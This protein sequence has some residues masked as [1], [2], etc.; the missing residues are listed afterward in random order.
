MTRFLFS[1]AIAVTLGCGGSAPHTEIVVA[2]AVAPSPPAPVAHADCELTSEHAR[3]TLLAPDG[4]RAVFVRDVQATARVLPIESNVNVEVEVVEPSFTLRGE[5][6]ADELV[7]TAPTRL[8]PLVWGTHSMW[9]HVMAA[10]PGELKLGLREY[11]HGNVVFEAPSEAWVGC[12]AVQ[13]PNG[14]QNPSRDLDALLAE[15]GASDTSEVW[16]RSEE[17]LE[18][19]ETPEGPTL[20]RWP[21]QSPPARVLEQRG[22]DTRVVAS[23]LPGTAVVGWVPTAA[24]MHEQGEGGGG[25]LGSLAGSSSATQI[26]PVCRLTREQPLVATHGPHQAEMGVLRPGA[27]VVRGVGGERGWVEIGGHPD[28]ALTLPYGP[29]GEP[30]TK[31]WVSG[32]ALRCD[33]PPVYGTSLRTLAT[34]PPLDLSASLDV[35]QASGLADVAPGASCSL[36]LTYRPRWGAFPC[37]AVVT[38][39]ERVLFGA[40]RHNGY[41]A[42]EVSQG[43]P[44]SVHAQDEHTTRED[45]GDAAL[46]LDTTAGSF[47][48]RD[49]ADGSFGVY[50][51]EGALS[52]LHVTS[53]P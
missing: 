50:A 20:A 43:P 19:R 4:W 11:A 31:W 25:L 23:F 52:G 40:E 28:D 44:L 21:V 12:D 35:T 32:D 13:L 1:F 3:I 5:F 10:R 15:L 41:L 24:V 34:Q 18:W 2:P 14:D 22:P 8:G 47:E 45:G 38:C 26:F 9:T 46:T 51:I 27:R 36:E 42:C 17:T 48:I 7:L 29:Q 39:G 30:P 37:R 49:S 6:A 16:L 53:R 33:E